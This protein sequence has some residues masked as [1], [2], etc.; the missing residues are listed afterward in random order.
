MSIDTNNKMNPYIGDLNQLISYD[1]CTL[2][3]GKQE[4]VEC[5]HIHNGGNLNVTILPGRGMDVYQM[6]YKGTNV[7]YIAPN[8]IISSKYYEAE[9]NGFLRNFYVGFMTTCGLQNIGGPAEVN[10]EKHGLH[11]RISNQPAENVNVKHNF[12]NGKVGLALSG[13]MREASIFNVNLRL[14][15][16]YSFVYGEDVIYV[17]DTITNLGFSSEKYLYAL[18]IN[19]GYPLLQPGT[20]LLLDTANVSPRDEYAG[21]Y[22]SSWKEIEEPECP[23]RERC[24]FHDLVENHEGESQYTIFNPNLKIG[25]NVKYSKKDFPY[26]VQWKMLG[27]GEYV[28]GLEPMNSPI[29]GPKIGEQGCKAPTIEPG[30]SKIFNY[31]FSFI[32]QL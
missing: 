9:G 19:Y 16:E 26:F 17:T 32:D 28:M 7:N 30:E 3:G 4:G 20:L 18:H 8:G 29:D 12:Q 27:K 24:Y 5:A 15:R 21:Q 11:G 10:G 25:V 1:L 23:Y 22:I 31:S 2:S 13:T 14:N 6:R